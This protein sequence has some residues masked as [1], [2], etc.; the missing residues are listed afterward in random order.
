M[1]K[2]INCKKSR[3]RS[4]IGGS[5]CGLIIGALIGGF[6]IAS[7]MSSALIKLSLA[8]PVCNLSGQ[9]ITK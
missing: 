8:K 4:F 7:L 3:I 2:N 9:I 5:V 6:T 1:N